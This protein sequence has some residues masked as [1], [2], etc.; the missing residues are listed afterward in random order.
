[1]AATLSSQS[2]LLVAAGGAAGAVLR[3]ATGQGVARLFGPSAAAFPAATLLVNMLGSFLVGL[4]AGW[5]MKRGGGDNLRLLLGVGL[6]GGF[7]TFSAFT[8]DLFV[9]LERG[10]A[11]LALFYAAA[12]LVAGVGALWLGLILT[13]S[14]A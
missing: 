12:S 9:L 2:I 11:T 7:T 3:F 14:L 5:L 1:M 8:L 6:L 4:L 10:A 13:R